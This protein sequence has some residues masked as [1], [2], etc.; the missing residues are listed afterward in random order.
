[1]TEGGP[2][3]EG[4]SGTAATPHGSATSPP[5][6]APSP[7]SKLVSVCEEKE[8]MHL[9]LEVDAQA[10]AVEAELGTRRSSTRAREQRSGAGAATAAPPTRRSLQERLSQAVQGWAHIWWGL[11]TACKATMIAAGAP[12][13][14]HACQHLPAA[15]AA[16]PVPLLLPVPLSSIHCPCPVP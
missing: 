10:D 13:C 1:M 8:M 2:V 6:D 12:T 16:D 3:P 14:L 9:P 4:G 7:S 5:A 11:P 15:A